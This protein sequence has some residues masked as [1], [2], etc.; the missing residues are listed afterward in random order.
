[1]KMLVELVRLESPGFPGWGQV[2]TS[3]SVHLDRLASQ[4]SSCC[5][6]PSVAATH[7]TQHVY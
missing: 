6:T 2:C 4:S 3:L 1:M 7:N 5:V